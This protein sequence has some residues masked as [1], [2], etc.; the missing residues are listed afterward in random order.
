V[1]G[2]IGFGYVPDRQDGCVVGVAADLEVRNGV[3]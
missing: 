1:L 3:I 2:L